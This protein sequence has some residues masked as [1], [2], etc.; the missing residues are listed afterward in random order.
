LKPQNDPDKKGKFDESRKWYKISAETLIK[1]DN[2]ELGVQEELCDVDPGILL[3]ESVSRQ[4]H[5]NFSCVGQSQ[6]F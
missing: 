5:G 4:F 2:G 3:L 1:V 6:N